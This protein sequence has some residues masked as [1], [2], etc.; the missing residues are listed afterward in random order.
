MRPRL[1]ASHASVPRRRYSIRSATAFV[2]AP[3]LSFCILSAP[4]DLQAET[5]TS[6][7]GQLRVNVTRVQI[8]LGETVAIRKAGAW[9]PILTASDAETLVGTAAGTAPAHCQTSSV[10]QDGGGPIVIQANCEAGLFT[11]RVG[12]GSEPDRIDIHVTLKPIGKA[13][14]PSIEDRYLFVPARRGSE[15]PLLAPLDFVWSQGIK[16]SQSDVVSS[17][18]F[19][20]PIVMFQQANLFAAIMPKMS[21]QPDAPLALDLDVTSSEKPWFSCGLVSTK[22]FGHSYF[23]RATDRTLTTSSNPLEYDYSIFAS[24]QPRKLGYQRMVR[25]L[26]NDMGHTQLIQ[27]VDLQRNA[28]KPTLELFDDWRQDAWVRYANEVYRGFP[29]GSKQCGTLESKRNPLG[30]WDKPASDALV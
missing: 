26:W 5:L 21:D 1:L 20:S 17:Y 8:G 7:D 22:P 28:T 24:T 12:L 10:S 15:T 14:V 2:L 11:R 4:G 19:K 13:A 6:R 27:S 23:R 25:Y 3:V 9:V 16:E 29:C 30:Q 18:Q